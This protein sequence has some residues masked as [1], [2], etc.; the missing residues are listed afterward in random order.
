MYKFLSLVVGTIVPATANETRSE[1]L[2]MLRNVPLNVARF[3]MML[4]SPVL[5][6]F[7]NKILDS[8]GTLLSFVA[9]FELVVM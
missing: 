1:G 7:K 3:A 4:T 9:A 8:L 5:E 2:T 6:L